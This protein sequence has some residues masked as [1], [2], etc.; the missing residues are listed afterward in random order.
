[1]K[2]DDAFY[3]Q[4][5]CR[6]DVFLQPHTKIALPIILQ[7]KKKKLRNSG[8]A[9]IVVHFLYIVLSK[10]ADLSLDER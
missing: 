9:Q 1:M 4:H 2:R 6:V 3:N 10:K 7:V 8:G 5:D